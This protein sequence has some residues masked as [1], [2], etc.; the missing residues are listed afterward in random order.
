[1]PDAGLKDVDRRVPD[2][3]AGKPVLSEEG[4]LVR[5]ET[6]CIWRHDFPSPRPKGGTSSVSSTRA[7]YRLSY[8]PLLR[9][10]PGVDLAEEVRRRPERLGQ[11]LSRTVSGF[12]DACLWLVRGGAVPRP[13]L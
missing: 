8:V 10:E 6:Y 7:A 5:P 11:I 4:T 12:A 9:G 2:T 3:A 1:M 13:R